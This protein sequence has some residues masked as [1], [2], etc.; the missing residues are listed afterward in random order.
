MIGLP[1]PGERI[2]LLGI[3]GTAMAS[4]AG[5]LS[6]LG[7]RVSG[8][9]QGVYPPMSTLLEQEAIPF[10]SPYSARNLPEDPV[11]V[12]VGNAI[13]R[14][15]PELEAALDRRL[16]LVSFPEALREMVLRSR[17]PLVVAGTHGKTTTTSL[18]A[19]ILVRSGADAGCLIGG[20]SE[21]L[22]GSFR[23][24]AEGA[25]FVLEGDEYDSAYWD[26]GPKFLHYL[27]EV[28]IIGNVEF[29]HADIY[30][31]F[32]A[33]RRA[34][35]FLARLPPRRGLLLL[36]A[37]SPAAL[38]LRE[39]AHT[40]VQ[41]FGLSETA[42]WKGRILGSGPSGSRLA[43]TFRD[44]EKPPLTGAFWGEAG[45][46]NVLAAAAAAAWVG[47]R[48]DRIREAVA[49]FEG[50]RRR[51]EPVGEARG[52][53]VVRDFAH[54]PTAVRAAIESAAARWPDSEIVAV[55][56]PRSFTSRSSVFQNDFAAAFAGARRVLLAGTL[57]PSRGHSPDRGLDLCRL[58]GDIVRSGVSAEALP[59]RD[60]LLSRISGIAEGSGP[61]V[62]LF[63]SNGWFG[64]VPEEVV[65]SATESGA[66]GAA[67]DHIGSQ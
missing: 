30:P 16:T 22:G 5:L 52:F 61:G 59:D 24:G 47:T 39:D 1:A 48:W 43:V 44:E 56:E 20:I 42:D 55:F 4:L 54:H 32:A 6:R 50:V 41:T 7:C 29:D 63:L 64:G 25:P 51:L 37:D 26:K 28:A 27:P 40:S 67:P 17:T 62:L 8:S 3:A 14:G 60:R 33:V 46:R 9:D 23:L 2:H 58:A 11:L 36:G 53:R 57:D 34:F 49:G 10:S 45:A 13:S 66:S 35:S 15:N 31:D 18:L 19:T 65:R 12:V 21:D 38:A